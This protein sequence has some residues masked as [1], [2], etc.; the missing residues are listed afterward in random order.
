M[1]SARVLPALSSGRVP[2]NPSISLT[3]S[4]NLSDTSVDFGAGFGGV[5]VVF[6]GLGSFFVWVYLG[7]RDKASVPEKMKGSWILH[8]S[9]LAKAS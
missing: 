6:I 9:S 4:L 3:K 8:P 1:A 2:A 5:I 7:C